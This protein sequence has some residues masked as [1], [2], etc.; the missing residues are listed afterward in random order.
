MP[1]AG[2]CPL[3]TLNPCSA[4]PLP[5]PAPCSLAAPNLRSPHAAG[6][7][8]SPE[9][10]K[11]YLMRGVD[12]VASM[13]GKCVTGGRLNAHKSLQLLQADLE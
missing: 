6:R 11:R 9:E 5:Q 8:L 1:Q 3:T 7:S 12:P 2:P 13:S 10:M 4:L